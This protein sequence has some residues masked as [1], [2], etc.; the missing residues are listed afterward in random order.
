MVTGLA[1]GGPSAGAGRGWLGF[2]GGSVAVPAGAGGVQMDRRYLPTGDGLVA[3][4]GVETGRQD[5]IRA[6]TSC[7]S[8]PRPVPS[9]T[10][11]PGYRGAWVD[12]AVGWSRRR[13][14]RTLGHHLETPV[15][16]MSC[17][18]S[19]VPV[20]GPGAVPLSNTRPARHPN[21]NRLDAR[22]PTTTGRDR[23]RPDDGVP[24]TSTPGPTPTHTSSS[25]TPFWG[26]TPGLGR[27]ACTGI[28]VVFWRVVE[29]G[30]EAARSSSRGLRL[31]TR[32]F[33]SPGSTT[34]RPVRWG[35]DRG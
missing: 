30:A 6:G 31:P 16:P 27:R 4:A 7:P 13:T 34:Q 24:A 3:C 17:P 23:P 1:V 15:R 35:S 2:R 26:P 5:R 11:R 25:R 20:C 18:R 32:W 22:R 9:C 8:S 21:T 10:P 33:R 19:P 28:V 29:R 12:A 14:T